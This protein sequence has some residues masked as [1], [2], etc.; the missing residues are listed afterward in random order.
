MKTRVLFY[1]LVLASLFIA[2][3]CK[4]V[5]ETV[6]ELGPE[7]VLQTE[8][9]VNGL[10]ASPSMQARVKEST[11]AD[12]RD[13]IDKLNNI[14]RQRNYDEWTKYLTQEYL[15]YYSDRTVLTEISQDPALKRF[16]IN[17]RTLRDYFNYVVFPSRQN[18]QVDDIEFMDNFDVIK[19]I[20]ID[21]RGERLVL[22]KLEKIGDIWKIAIW[23]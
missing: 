17:L 11:L 3:A 5:P 2:L 22:Y 12:V 10:E 18:S 9:Q 19:V 23:R 6:P 15:D 20:W 7:D 21:S 1:I 16:E 8:E 4:T 13:F 14:I